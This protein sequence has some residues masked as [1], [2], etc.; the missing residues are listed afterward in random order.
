MIL[1][2]DGL[3]GNGPTKI[4]IDG[5]LGGLERFW[6]TLALLGI[7]AAMPTTVGIGFRI[8]RYRRLARSGIKDIDRFGGKTF[9]EYLEVLFRRLG[10]KVERTRF[11]GDYGGDLVLR[12]GGVRTVVQ[13]KR[14]AKSVGVRAV[15]EVVA[16]K[17]YYDCDETLVVSNSRYTKQAEELARRNDVELWDRDMLIRQL[18]A[19]GAKQAARRGI[20][21]L[22]H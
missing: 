9:E 1:L 19:T 16:A 15:Q 2:A 5:L 22:E 21:A 3:T 7:L 4:L 13:A 14:H 11:V 17:G 18:T 10:Y 6:S 12:K 20:V 8:V